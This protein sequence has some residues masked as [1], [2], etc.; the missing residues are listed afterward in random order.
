MHISY[1]F[2]GCTTQVL[3]LDLIF[4]FE[5]NLYEMISQLCTLSK[6]KRCLETDSW[7]T[8]M[9]LCCM[10]TLHQSNI[11]CW[12][13]CNGAYWWHCGS[14]GTGQETTVS[15]WSVWGEGYMFNLLRQGLWSAISYFLWSETKSIIWGANPFCTIFHCC[16]L[17]AIR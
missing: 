14:V 15:M 2:L 17:V 13:R 4:L 3:A 9:G 7:A 12:S 16:F 11:F 10:C 8:K 1:V 5:A 6:E